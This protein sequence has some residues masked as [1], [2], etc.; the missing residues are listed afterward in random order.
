MN[1]LFNRFADA[2]SKVVANAVFFAFCVLLVLVWAPSLPI[3][4]SVDTWQLVINTATT[5]VTF[6]LVALLHNSEQRFE[7]ASNARLIAI[8]DSLGIE[9][10]VNDGGQKPEVAP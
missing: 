4:G 2:T 7:E 9:D 5:I 6:L 8:L 1:K 10:P 3:F